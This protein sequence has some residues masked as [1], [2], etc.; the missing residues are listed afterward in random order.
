MNMLKFI[1]KKF[2]VDVKA[3]YLLLDI[4]LQDVSQIW[5]ACHTKYEAQRRF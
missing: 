2:L 5:G 3:K 4:E 1:D